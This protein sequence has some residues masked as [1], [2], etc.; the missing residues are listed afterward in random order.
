MECLVQ[1]LI[2][3]RAV[4]GVFFHGLW[5]RVLKVNSYDFMSIFPKIVL[6]SSF[7]SPRN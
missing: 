1:S 4:L 2:R 7:H 6:R 5:Q 3:L